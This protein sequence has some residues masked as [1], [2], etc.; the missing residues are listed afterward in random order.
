LEDKGTDG[1]VI[2]KIVL[3]EEGV[4]SFY[5]AEDKDNFGLL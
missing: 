2:L 4:N 5:L 1:R 3:R